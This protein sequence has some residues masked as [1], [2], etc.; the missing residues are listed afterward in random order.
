MLLVYSRSVST[1]EKCARHPVK[2]HKN[3]DARILWIHY[4]WTHLAK[5]LSLMFSGTETLETSSFVEVA[6]R[7][8]WFTLLVR[9]AIQYQSCKVPVEI[10]IL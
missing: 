5:Y 4:V 1:R 3:G 7:Y 6:T 8:L 10:M 2:D 9:E